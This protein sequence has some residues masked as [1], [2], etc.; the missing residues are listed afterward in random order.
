MNLHMF[1]EDY[2]TL[3]WDA[4]TYITGQINYGGRVTDDLDR[5]CLM[6]ILGMYYNR[7][8]VE[9]ETYPLSQSGKYIVPATDDYEQVLAHIKALPAT[10]DPE[11][12]GMSRNADI[13][14]QLQEAETLLSTVLS[15]QPRLGSSSEGGEPPEDTV[16]NT[17]ER[18]LQHLPEAL[19]VKKA[20]PDSVLPLPSGQANSLGTVLLHE[21]VKFNRCGGRW[22]SVRLTS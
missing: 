20:H 18:L 1:I 10:E 19:D 4:L 9:K 3:P 15:I 21:C 22:G 14:F 5:R 7:D 12:F 13:V 2:P 16:L 11:V 6:C 8:V 17:A